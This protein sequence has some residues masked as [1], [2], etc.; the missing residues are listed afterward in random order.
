M[1]SI[2][3]Y[4]I[5]IFCIVAVCTSASKAYGQDLG[6]ISKKDI[7]KVSGG[8]GLQTTAYTAF[9]IP[10]KRDPFLW[11]LNLNLNINILGVI[12]APFSATIS[13]QQSTVSQP[14]PFN[15]FGISPKY[16]A[17][18]AHLG[19]RSISLSEFSLSGNQFLGIGVEIAPKN[20]FIKG[21]ALYG[22]FAQP[23]YLNP[24]GTLASNPSFS[25]SGWGTG[26]TFG[27]SS[28]NEV[29]VNLFRATDNP[30]SL[31]V[32]IDELTIRPSENFI[33][34]V[35][36]KQTITKK[37]SVE[38][39]IDFSAITYNTEIEEE[40]VP[41]NSYVN[42]IFLFNYNPSS[43]VKK[44][45]KGGINY[46]L[47]AAK[48]Q[49]KYRRVDPGYTSLGTSFINNDYEDLSL[50]TSFALLKKRLN[51][52]LSGGGQRNN[53]NADKV[54]QLTRLIGSL[55]A[56]Y[57]INDK[58]NSS[59]NVSNFTSSTK[60]IIV[61]TFDSLKFVQ[62][63]KSI[64]GSVSRTG[65]TDKLTNALSIAANYQDAIVNNAKMNTFYNAN[66]SWQL[67]FP[68]KKFGIGAT[69]MGIQ[70]ITEINTT[71]NIG[72]SLSIRKTLF[73]DKFSLS[74]V[75]AYLN[76][77]S[78]GVSNGEI[79]SVSANGGMSMTKRSKLSISAANIRRT[80][81]GISSAELTAN[82]NLNY[83][84]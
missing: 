31:D 19:Y 82:I 23:V 84:F 16:K 64:G 39:E 57:K 63:T 12:S 1:R 46:K 69:M 77:F 2:T 73:K 59:L 47:K 50:K 33:F 20:S 5:S 8:A 43:A 51:L 15:N 32:P 35:V 9:G 78:D 67:Q 71:M 81:N 70:T 68:K 18:T 11:Q 41:G 3:P 6:N 66:V 4:I 29:T 17:V 37:L 45:I 30:N 21:K 10:A 22:Q 58:W 40:V 26:I 49:L 27:R 65:G 13:S 80:V 62:T 42:N 36:T 83:S 75:A 56:S 61:V 24:D 79:I 55:S 28:K 48:F 53:L 76:N 25:R 74:A 34:G 7:L 14:Q 72:P 54:A 60:Q 38:G 44:A 52:S